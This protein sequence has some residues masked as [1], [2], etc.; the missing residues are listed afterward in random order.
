MN[1]QDDYKDYRAFKKPSRSRFI[2]PLY[3]ILFGIF[4]GVMM[5][6]YLA[7][8]KEPVSPVQ[9]TLNSVN[10][11]TH[12]PAPVLD[13][14]PPEQKHDGR[15]SYQPEKPHKSIHNDRSHRGKLFICLQ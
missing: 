3:L 10:A 7:Q 4:I 2:T 8:N 12:T 14:S 9:Q 11:Q 6:T 5:K 15:D 1:Y 13:V